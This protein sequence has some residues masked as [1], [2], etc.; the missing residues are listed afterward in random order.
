MAL[1]PLFMDSYAP[2]SDSKQKVLMKPETTCCMRSLETRAGNDASKSGWED[3]SIRMGGR[4]PYLSLLA[5]RYFASSRFN[6]LCVILAFFL[7]L[8]KVLF[9]IVLF[10]FIVY[11][12]LKI[13]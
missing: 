2:A 4:D 11:M 5:W 7:F 13:F 1:L 9:H 6:A 3:V 10:I 8:K 12:G